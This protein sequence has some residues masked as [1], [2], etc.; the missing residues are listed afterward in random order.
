MRHR[1][2]VRAGAKGR[3][4]RRSATGGRLTGPRPRVPF[5]ADHRGGG[6]DAFTTAADGMR[7]LIRDL[8]TDKGID[9]F[10]TNEFLP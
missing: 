8:E 6:M 2:P 4:A 1:A 5:P 3:A 7:P 10:Y 9:A